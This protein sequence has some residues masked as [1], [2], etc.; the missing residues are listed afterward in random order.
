MAENLVSFNWDLI[1]KTCLVHYEVEHMFSAVCSDL[2]IAG[3]LK[4]VRQF[5]TYQPRRIG[6]DPR[7]ALSMH[8]WGIAVD[9][10]PR[11]YPYGGYKT[12]PKRMIEIF[13]DND[14]LW[15]GNFKVPDPMHFE[16]AP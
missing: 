6:L 8:A 1:E 15:G 14:F 5:Y 3:L 9:V 12:P 2:S 11:K 4:H 13:E 10:D 16:V 7:K